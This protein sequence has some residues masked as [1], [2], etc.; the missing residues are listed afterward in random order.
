MLKL[1]KEQHLG[2]WLYA[3]PQIYMGSGC[4]PAPLNQWILDV[5]QI[6]LYELQLKLKDSGCMPVLAGMRP[7]AVCQGPVGSV[8]RL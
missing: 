5:C 7:V 3:S 8:V 2:Q 4:M 1:S 6:T